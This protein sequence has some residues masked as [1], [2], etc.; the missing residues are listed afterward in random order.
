MGTPQGL[1]A[2]GD[3]VA[4][5]SF[6]D[7]AR[8]TLALGAGSRSKDFPHIFTPN[9]DPGHH[10]HVPAQNQHPGYFHTFPQDQDFGGHFHA[11]VQ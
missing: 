10:F 9:Q 5:Q 6:L 8:R 7:G 4:A 3:V 11:N 2:R 1:G